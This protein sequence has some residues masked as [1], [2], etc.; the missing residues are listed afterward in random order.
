MHNFMRD[1][2]RASSIAI[3]L[4]VPVVLGA[5]I[6]IWLDGAVRSCPLFLI[7]GTVLGAVA[8]FWNAYKIIIRLD[9]G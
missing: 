4:V 6:G 1:A 7:I 9:K 8:G 5:A 3:E 2:G